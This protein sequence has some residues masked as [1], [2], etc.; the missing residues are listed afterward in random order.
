MAGPARE[1]PARAGGLLDLSLPWTTLAG[2]LPEPGWLGRLGPVTSV[3]A[4]Q[5][6][7]LAVGDP[8]TEWRIILLTPS[9]Q[10]RGVA[11]IPRRRDGPSEQADLERA[12]PQ[13]ADPERGDP[14]RAGAGRGDNEHAGAGLVGRVTLTVPDTVLDRAPPDTAGNLGEILAAALRAASRAAARADA[15]EAADV[16]AGGCAHRAATHAYRPPASLRDKVTARDLTCRFPTCRQPVWRCDLDH[17][18]PWEA[19]GRT[20]GCNLGGLCRAHHKIKQHP[21]WTLR[22]DTPGIFCWTTPAGRTYTVTP[23]IHAA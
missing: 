20:C 22:Q 4:R 23:D 3:Q 14:E 17:T 21:F 12:D 2:I 9:G 19:G 11:R 16:M 15:A 5:L 6:A 7:D 1:H 8:D 13:R 10:A 18:L